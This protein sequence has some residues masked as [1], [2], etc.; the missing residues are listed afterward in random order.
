[1]RGGGARPGRVELLELVGIPLP[2]AAAAR[3]PAPA[4]RR[5][6][7]AGDDRDGGGLPARAAR[8][9]RADHRAGRDRA[10]RHPRRAARPAR[11]RLGTA[12]LLI[13]HDL[14]VVADIADRV[15]GDVRRAA[16]SSRPTS[17]RCSPRRSHPYTRGLLDAVPNPARHAD[18]GLREIPG[19]VPTLRALAGRLHVRRPVRGSRRA[20]PDARPRAGAGAG[21][22]TRCA[23]GTRCHDRRRA[24]ARRR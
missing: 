17:T 2:G 13:T 1:M 12:V 8:R 15:R 6:A 4:L 10:G 19:R 20:V 5:H 21:R 16:P 24:V 14:G 23:A 22:R 7:A 18:G 3:V 9:R 11:P